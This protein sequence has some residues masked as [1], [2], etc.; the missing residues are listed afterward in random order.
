MYKIVKM[1]TEMT[2]GSE[3]HV[4]FTGPS[5]NFTFY[6][7]LTLI[8]MSQVSLERSTPLPLGNLVI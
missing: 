1:N 7:T 5:S 4:I 8:N 2:S 6:K 3:N